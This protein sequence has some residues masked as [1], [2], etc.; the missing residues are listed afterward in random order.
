VIA[1]V[2]FSDTVTLGSAIVMILIG[3]LGVMTLVYGARWKAAFSVAEANS[4]AWKETA[5]RL[6]L[7][8]H[9]VKAE[10]EKV[11]A[12]LQELEMMPDVTVV[13]GLL[14]DHIAVE[15]GWW[16]THEAKAEDRCI[17]LIAAIKQGGPV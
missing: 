10:L 13:H 3:L 12:R 17:R 16:E 2:N 8:L 15:R 11:R 7:E 14:L 6:E 1:N 4:D 5:Q 9:D